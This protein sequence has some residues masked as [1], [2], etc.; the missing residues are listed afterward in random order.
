M[1]SE[2][3]HTWRSSLG[4]ETGFCPESDHQLACQPLTTSQKASVRLFSNSILSALHGSQDGHFLY[5]TAAHWPTT[6]DNSGLQEASLGFISLGNCCI[7][8]QTSLFSS[9]DPEEGFFVFCHSLVGFCIEHFAFCGFIYWSF[10]QKNKVK[11]D[12]FLYLLLSNQR[13]KTQR[14]KWQRQAA[15]LLI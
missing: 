15:N 9:I 13:I 10:P 11:C 14:H 8:S 3:E 5:L 2:N 12:V 6:G 7:E 1:T 4:E